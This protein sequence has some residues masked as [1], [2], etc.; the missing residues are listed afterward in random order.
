[1]P[2]IE[3]SKADLEN[4]LG[5]KIKE[6]ELE[7]LFTFVKGE[8]E[9]ING[10]MLK[11]DIKDTNR[12]DLWSVEGIARELKG[13][14][15]IETGLPKYSVGKSNIS[16]V[17]DESVKNIRPF[18]VCAV[19]E[20][21]KLSDALIRELMQL[22]EK[23][24]MTFG[25]R[26]EYVAIGI[27]DLD[28]I[29]GK[30]ITYKA[31]GFEE[32][33]FPPLGF[34]EEMT[35]KQILE[36]HPK[37]KEYGHL[38]NGKGKAPVLLDESQSVISMPPI[39]NSNT[40]GKVTEETRN[41]FIDVTGLKMEDVMTA[42]NVVVTA[43]ADRGG[44]IKSVVLDYGD[45]KMESP[46]LKPRKITVS[47]EKIRKILG[48]GISSSEI[49]RLLRE[50]RYD[51]EIIDEENE[52]IDAFYLPTRQDILHWRDVAEDVAISFGY[53]DFETDPIKV[54]CVGETDRF[55]D[56]SDKIREVLV[57]YSLQEVMTFTLTNK[58]I[59]FKKM[60]R[61]EKDIVEIANPVSQNW[62]NIRCDVMPCL[63]EFLSKNTHVEYPQ[64][65]FEVGDVVVLDENQDV[66]TRTER[67]V[68]IMLAG[69]DED[70]TKIKE[71]VESFAELLGLKFEYE[72]DNDSAFI[73]G[74][75]AKI[76]LDNVK[77]GV[78][79]EISPK[80]LENF[81]VKVPVAGVELNLTKIFEVWEKKK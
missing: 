9:E 10:D 22:Q 2:T 6:G 21:V 33:S 32:I 45:K 29:N 70:F 79:G 49:V 64:R 44:K 62:T 12:P 1:M 23:I 17:V 18:V 34:E 73:P 77:I 42:L 50:A 56:F 11:I 69:N 65:I 68:C 58:E 40:I 27:S 14:L 81:D 57:G 63:M 60:N 5:R 15:R 25:R 20:N 38:I 53:N 78:L 24:H 8:L 37:G 26:R 71:I 66:K 36:E 3:I 72:E 46:D 80:V 7:D 47:G 16:V 13:H 43:L 48:L 28:K 54:K 76:M 31:V 67:R 59:M 75:C 4:L 74:R 39:I 41:L 52:I 51:A 61:E 19:I 35:P 30:R 55:E